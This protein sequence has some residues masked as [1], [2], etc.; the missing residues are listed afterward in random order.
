MFI[1]RTQLISLIVVSSFV[2][3]V[4]LCPLSSVSAAAT[5]A[6]LPLPKEIVK[7]NPEKIVLPH[8]TVRPWFPK[9]A[10]GRVDEAD[11]WLTVKADSAW[12]LYGPSVV[13]V[14]ALGFKFEEIAK[15]VAVQTTVEPVK[16]YKASKPSILYLLV[17][18]SLISGDEVFDSLPRPE[19]LLKIDSI[20]KAVGAEVKIPINGKFSQDDMTDGN[21]VLKVLVNEAGMPRRVRL[22]VP[23][24]VG[25]PDSMAVQTARVMKFRPAISGGKSIATWMTWPFDIK[26]SRYR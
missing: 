14:S 9:A 1:H 26:G 2:V 6:P 18:F 3:A 5:M 8:Q 11:V 13:Y 4:A 17:S 24:G 23:S 22:A 10:I 12:K 25:M 20:V 7:I 19:Q 15:M 16:G 21:P